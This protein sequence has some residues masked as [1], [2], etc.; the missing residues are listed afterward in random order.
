V[1][2]FWGW[3]ALAFASG[4]TRLGDEVIE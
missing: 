1:S 2:A 4:T 3:G